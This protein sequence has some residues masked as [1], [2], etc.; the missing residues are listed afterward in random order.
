MYLSENRVP[1]TT[2]GGTT[3]Y[4]WKK[5]HERNEALDCRVYAMGAVYYLAWAYAQNNNLE[6]IE[7]VQFWDSLE[8]GE[9]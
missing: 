5:I 9:L 6:Y 3:V 8:N 4:R 1:E 7:W 2:K